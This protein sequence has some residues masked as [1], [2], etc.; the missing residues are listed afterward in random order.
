MKTRRI[1]RN[2][3]KKAQNRYSKSQHRIYEFKRRTWT[4]RLKVSPELIK[5]FY[6]PEAQAIND[7]I[8]QQQLNDLSEEV[9]KMAMTIIT[10]AEIKE[11]NLVGDKYVIS[12]DAIRRA[13]VPQIGIE[14]TIQH[15]EE[16]S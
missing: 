10:K 14:T 9:D 15:H 8:I 5:A 6:S 13:M 11:V 1:I 3:V 12:I 16:Q 7:Y 4:L 2:Q